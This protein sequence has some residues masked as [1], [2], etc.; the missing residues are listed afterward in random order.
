MTLLHGLGVPELFSPELTA[1][2]EFKLAQME[3]GQ[4]ARDAFMREI[5][6]DDE[7]HRRARRRTT[8]ATRSPATSRRLP[9]G[10]RNAAARCTS[11][12]RNSS[13]SRCDFGFWKIMAGRQLE[14]ARGR[15]AA[16]RRARSDRSTGFR[17]KLGRPFTAH[18]EAHRRERSRRST[19]ATATATTTTAKRR[20]SPGR[21]RSAPAR[22]AVRACSRLP[23][24]YVCEKA[25]GPGKTCDFRS[26]RVIL[27]RPIERA[28]MA[29]LLA[30]GKTDLLQFVSARTRRP[31]SAFLV[32]QKDGKIGFEF[33]ARDAS[34]AQ[35]RAARGAP[36]R[37]SV[38]GAHPKRWQAGRAARGPLRPVREARRRERHAAGSRH[39]STR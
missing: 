14:P 32:R 26:G 12:T 27:Q 36:R 30:T 34:Q 28:Q 38:L 24:A 29:K 4:L 7:A 9:R 11:A 16:A 17:S 6:D 10:A 22:N 33:E 5:V 15:R 23:Q 18:A 37:C 25:V 31:F 35:A 13:A 2:W 21:S 39:A 19:S 1:E 3:H 8:R 20:I